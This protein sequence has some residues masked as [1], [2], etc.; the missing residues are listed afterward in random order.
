MPCAI[1]TNADLL[2]R[3]PV[4]VNLGVPIYIYRFATVMGVNQPSPTVDKLS[5]N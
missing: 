2:A 1:T 3:Q 5:K 4:I